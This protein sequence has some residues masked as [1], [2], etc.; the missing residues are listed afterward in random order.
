M[1]WGDLDGGWSGGKSRGPGPGV[2]PENAVAGAAIEAAPTR[3]ASL[4]NARRLGI[5]TAYDTGTCDD[6]QGREE[7]KRVFE[8]ADEAFE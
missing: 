3:A 8:E 1:S 7:I 2:D 5:G 4:R 6:S